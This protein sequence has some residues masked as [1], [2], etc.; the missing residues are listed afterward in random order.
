MSAAFSKI[1][2]VSIEE[3]YRLEA[4][5]EQ[6]HDYDAGEVIAMAGGSLSHSRIISNFIRE[7]GTRL[8]GRPCEVLDPGFKIGFPGRTYSHYADA[9]LVR[10]GPQTDPRDRSDQTLINPTAI[11]EVLSP[12]TAGFDRSTKLDRYRELP[13]FSEY[14]IVFQDRREV[15]TYFKQDD[16]RW[17]LQT[18]ADETGEVVLRSVGI[19]LPLAE[20]YD[21]VTVGPSPEAPSPEVPPAGAAMPGERPPR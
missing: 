14:V 2:Y 8:K 5:S 1:A 10:G 6:R 11:V 7:A 13:S 17:L 15:Q 21:R 16:G 19:T 3:Y 20:I 12:S 9:T 18:F 4:E